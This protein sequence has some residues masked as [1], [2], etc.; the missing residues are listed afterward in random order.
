MDMKEWIII[1]GGALIGLIVLHG[2]WIA[3]RHGRDPLRVKIQPGLLAE[4][5]DDG[6]WLSAELPNGGARVVATAD[7]QDEEED[8]DDGGDAADDV[9]VLL[10]TAGPPGAD[11]AGAASELR[12]AVHADRAEE[13]AAAAPVRTPLAN[14]EPIVPER[15]LRS[16]HDVHDMHKEAPKSPIRV[17]AA[18]DAGSSD[19]DGTG[20]EADELPLEQAAFAH[21]EVDAVPEAGAL[22]QDSA[23]L[24]DDADGGA[25]AEADRLGE[26]VA[27]DLL[28]IHMLA[29]GD[30][31]FSGDEL[32][33]TMRA[34]DLRFGEMN[35]FHRIDATTGETAFSVVRAVE[36]GSFDLTRVED[37][38]SPGLIAFL[39]LPSQGNAV[40]VLEDMMRT[41]QAMADDLGGELLDE[42]RKPFTALAAE[43]Y[44]SRAMDFAQPQMLRGQGARKKLA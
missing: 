15:G 41:V 9:P 29:P 4:D 16:M 33:S 11:G 34:Q 7:S 8:A 25:E 17:D 22:M 35:I 13:T 24:F 37:C 2:L 40:E 27:D 6:G 1:G 14:M 3:W 44:R 31:P 43:G 21:S 19:A 30:E 42:N 20:L 5:A 23:T 10:E 38:A 39:Q 12:P 28:V 18:Q 32:L 26:D 36:P